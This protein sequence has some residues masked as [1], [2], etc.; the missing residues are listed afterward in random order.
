M[1]SI[2][3]QG[4]FFDTV[5][6]NLHE[7]AFDRNF[8]IECFLIFALNLPVHWYHLFVSIRYHKNICFSRWDIGQIDG[9]SFVQ[10]TE[11]HG[12]CTNPIDNSQWDLI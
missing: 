3:L 2:N 5:V 6:S 4:M 10:N 1:I 11:F 7:F 12:R 9:F 8:E